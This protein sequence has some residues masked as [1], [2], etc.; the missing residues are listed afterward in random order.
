MSPTPDPGTEDPYEPT[1]RPPL[2]YAEQALLGAVLL[3]PQL[4]LALEDLDTSAFDSP[5]HAAVF[6]AMHD[7]PAPEEATSVGGL[8]WLNTVLAKAR[9][10]TPGLP[11]RTCTIWSPPAPSPSTPPRTPSSSAPSTP[12][13]PSTTTPNSSHGPPQT[14]PCRNAPGTPSPPPTTS[15]GTSI[16]SRDVSPPMPARCPAPRTRRPPDRQRETRGGRP[17]SGC[18]QA[19]SPG[20]SS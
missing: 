2:Y 16:S 4:L 10:Q 11:P 17:N 18:S 19:R 20:Q 15:H 8:D 3:Q 6:A 5:V 1:E 14:P 13:A 12:G 7:V 9:T